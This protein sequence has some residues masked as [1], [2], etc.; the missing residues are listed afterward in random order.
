MT[1]LARRLVATYVSLLLVLAAVG[2]YGQTRHRHHA[3]LIDAKDEAIVTLAARRSE[4]AVVN[5]PLAITT[6]ARAHG[7]VPAPEA[8]EVIA[9]APSPVPPP[10]PRLDAPTLEV[11][12]VWR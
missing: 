4:A 6:W 1:R 7:M 12:T 11:R 2:A 8:S 5:G 3:Q 10:A 9:V